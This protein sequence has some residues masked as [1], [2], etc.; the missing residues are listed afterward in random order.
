[1]P[2]R[3]A[4][5]RDYAFRRQPVVITNLFEGQEISKIN[6]ID[7]EVRAWREQAVDHESDVRSLMKC[8]AEIAS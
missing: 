1:M 4:F 3:D 2:D 5:F 7:G 8:A 6:T